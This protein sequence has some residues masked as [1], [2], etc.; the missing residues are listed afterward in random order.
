MVAP[1]LLSSQSYPPTHMP[2]SSS[3]SPSFSLQRR[4][5]PPI[6]ICPSTLSQIKTIASSPTEAKQGRPSRIKDPKVGN[7]D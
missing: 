6:P 4:G 7:R 2:F 3:P 5:H 1:F